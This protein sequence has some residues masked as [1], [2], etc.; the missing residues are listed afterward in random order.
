M[1][2]RTV[3]YEV[4]FTPDSQSLPASFDHLIG[5]RAD[6]RRDGETERFD[7]DLLSDALLNPTFPEAEVTKET[8]RRVDSAHVAKDN[9][10]GALR[11]YFQAAFFG[12]EHPYGNPADETTLAR[13]RRE[14]I[15]EYHK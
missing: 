3:P 6:G 15:V 5:V 14:D 2:I 7:A 9:A 1:P 4:L 11:N 13:I 12:K 10:Q 8:A